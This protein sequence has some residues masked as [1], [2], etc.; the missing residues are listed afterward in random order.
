[1]GSYEPGTSIK[2]ALGDLLLRVGQEFKRESPRALSL[3]W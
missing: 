3:N 1:M 2:D